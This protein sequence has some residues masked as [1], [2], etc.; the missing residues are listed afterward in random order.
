MSRPAPSEY[1][2]PYRGYVD[3]VRES[4]I[5]KTLGEQLDE[6]LALLHPV[7]E[8]DGN[9]RHPP[10]TWSVKEVVG[11]LIDADRIFGC[12][13]LRFARGDTTP[14]PGFDENPYVRAAEFDRCPLAELIDE[15]ECIRR[16]HLWLFRH[17]PEAA[18]S[19]SGQASG[20]A[21][22]VRA[23][24]FIMAGHARHHIGILRQ[25]LAGTHATDSKS[26]S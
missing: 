15:F 22:S 4:D 1:A 25:R 9:V 13:A 11:H 2:A 26:S 6:V 23:L 19:R 17:L 10:Y 16:S 7:P 8:T 21:V 3:L 18:W 14:L 5:V 24:A 20:H 12:R